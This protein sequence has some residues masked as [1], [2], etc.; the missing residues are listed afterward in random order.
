MI[1]LPG[2]KEGEHGAGFVNFLWV[3]L[4]NVAL[5]EANLITMVGV[6]THIIGC[7]WL[8]FCGWSFAQLEVAW[9][10]GR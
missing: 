9:H 6:A 2:D 10:E 1:R 3:E 4:C 8:G 7:T 5:T